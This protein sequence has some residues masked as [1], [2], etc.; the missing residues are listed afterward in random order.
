MYYVYIL[1][2]SNSKYY[3]GSTGDIRGRIAEHNAGKVI[4]T[5]GLKPIKLVYYCAFRSKGKALL[6]EKYLKTGSGIGFRNKRL[7]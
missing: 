5:K 2:L 6:F 7:I 3:A 4:S 1:K